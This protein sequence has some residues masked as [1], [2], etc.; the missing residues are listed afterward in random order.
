V[1][2]SVTKSDSGTTLSKE[3]TTTTTTSK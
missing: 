2:G 3:R 1:S